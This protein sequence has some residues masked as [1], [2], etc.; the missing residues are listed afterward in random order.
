MEELASKPSHAF[1]LI[2]FDLD[3]VL[4]NS[5]PVMQ[6]AFEAALFDYFGHNLSAQERTN[7]FAQFRQH[8]GK[9]FPQIMSAI[10]LPQA[11]HEPFKTHSRYLAQYVRPYEGVSEMLKTLKQWGLKMTVATGKDTD[12]AREL[13]VQL[14]LIQY[15]ETVTGSDHTEAPK[16]APDMAQQH[17]V[18]LRIDPTQAMIIGDSPSDLAC[19]RAANIRCGAALWGYNNEE[20]LKAYR[21]DAFFHSPK[22]LT[23]WIKG[24][25]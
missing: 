21:P 7:Y 19:G 23:Q 13:L 24:R 4:I 10:N 16:P 3:G 20:T 6:M 17:L 22:Q 9:G 2:I 5:L 12:R 14:N 1:K 18:K 15:F 11:L 8:L 25:L